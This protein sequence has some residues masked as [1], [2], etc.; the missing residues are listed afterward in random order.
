VNLR[1]R[2]IAL[3]RMSLC[4]R[5]SDDAQELHCAE[6]DYST[7]LSVEWTS[8]S[9]GSPD[10]QPYFK[11][12]LLECESKNPDRVDLDINRSKTFAVRSL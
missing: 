4:I 3:H 2:R 10:L 12:R 11:L 1:M 7:A 8:Y 9:K 5:G 6:Y